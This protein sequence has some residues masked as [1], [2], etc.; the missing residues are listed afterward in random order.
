M[1]WFQGC[2]HPCWF[3]GCQLDI[4]D[5]SGWLL[6]HGCSSASMRN[7]VLWTHPWRSTSSVHE[8]LLGKFSLRPVLRT[9][10]RLHNFSLLEPMHAILHW[11]GLYVLRQ[12]KMWASLLKKSR[13]RKRKAD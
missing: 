5:R 1:G 6:F 2:H 11:L 10:R 12:Q 4:A 7:E 9:Q 13:H 8:W 3:Q